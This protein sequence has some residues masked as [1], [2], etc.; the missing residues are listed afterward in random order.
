MSLWKGA[1]VYFSANILTALIPFLLLPI[2]TR[3]LSPDEYGQIAMFQTLL[4]ALG[5]L[6]GFNVIGAASRK[7]YDGD[8]DNIILRQFNGSCIQILLVTNVISFI[9]VMIFKNKISEFLGIPSDWIFSAILISASSFIV[10]MRLSQW[11]IRSNAKLF[12]V[13]QVTNSLIN[14]LLSLL[15][16]VILVQGAQG[17]IEAQLI[18]CFITGIVAFIL[19]YKDN[20]IDI[21]S[22]K[23]EYIKEALSFGIPLIPHHVGGL[24]ILSASRIVINEQ[25]SLFDVGIYMVAFQ[26]STTMSILFDALNKAYVPWLFER[27]KR[28]NYEEKKQIVKYT[29]CYFIVVLLISGIIFLIGPFFITLIAG[30]KY[31]EAGKL[32]GLLCLGQTFGGMYLMVTNYMF[33]SKKTGMLSLV[34]ISTGLI[35][36]FLLFIFIEYLGLIGVAISFSIAKLIQFLSTWFMASNCT[37]MPWKL[38]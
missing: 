14:M 20:L 34:T 23:P 3:Y 10:S 30:D 24:L 31:S 38:Q 8:I 22:F 35:N 15:L 9:V 1:S 17:R 2:L 7:Y 6:V 33:F 13:F 36:F 32:I 37:N 4:S 29:Y 16:V 11:Q 26:L 12:G 27:L 21:K 28:D 25:L 19:L 5:V 18:T